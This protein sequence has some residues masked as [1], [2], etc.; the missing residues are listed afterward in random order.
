METVHIGSTDTLEESRNV[1]VVAIVATV[2]IS[3]GHGTMLMSS[4]EELALNYGLFFSSSQHVNGYAVLVT[5]VHLQGIDTGVVR[6]DPPRF[7]EGRRETGTPILLGVNT[8]VATTWA[9]TKHSI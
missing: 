9:L 7:F 6:V 8:I 5:T 2:V 1:H 3:M 4:T